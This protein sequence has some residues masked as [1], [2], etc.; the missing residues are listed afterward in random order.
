[1]SYEGPGGGFGRYR[2]PL[3]LAAGLALYG[4][5]RFDATRP[6]AGVLLTYGFPPMAA[7]WGSAP[8][9]GSSL[10]PLALGVGGIGA[11]AAELGIAHALEPGVELFAL[12]PQSVLVVVSGLAL[13]GAACVHTAAA[14]KGI[15][16][17]FSAWMGMVTML[18]LYLPSHVKVG[19]DALDAFVAALLVSLFVGG[20]AGLALGGVATRLRNKATGKTT[21]PPETPG[22]KG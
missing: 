12:V 10:W 20:G 17:M 2:L 4:A 14:G 18:N 9:R 19:K 8:M 5:S 11:A 13:L 16:N 1:M 7:I 21:A 15:R 3:L 6:V 22:K